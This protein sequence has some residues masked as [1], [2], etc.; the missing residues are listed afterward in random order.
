[1]DMPAEMQA[2]MMAPVLVPQTKSNQSA[3]TKSGVPNRARRSASNFARISTVI[4]PR[5]PPPSQARIFL[6]PE[7][8]TRTFT[9]S[10]MVHLHGSQ[11]QSELRASAR[12]DSF[13]VARPA[14]CF[15]SFGNGLVMTLNFVGYVF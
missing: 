13:A 11:H 12:D 14:S 8:S 6:G 15:G 1:M 2:A 9:C 10:L 3:R 7:E 5:I 4:S